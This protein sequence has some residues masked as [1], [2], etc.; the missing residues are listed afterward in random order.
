MISRRM[1]GKLVFGG[2]RLSAAVGVA[3][4]VGVIGFGLATPLRVP[5]Q[6]EQR[7]DAPL[8][9]FEV[10]SIKL[11]QSGTRSR[12]FQFPDPGRFTTL[13]M[14]AKDMIEFA[15]NLKP[16]QVSGGPSWIE[17]ERVRY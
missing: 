13:N 9:S 17:S 1:P 3:L 14:P 6:S 12:L 11:D 7:A 2:K 15:Y 5:A 10:A 8:P 16:F 4:I